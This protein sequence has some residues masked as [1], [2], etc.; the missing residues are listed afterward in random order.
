MDCDVF[1]I[2]SSETPSS[3]LR[4]ALDTPPRERFSE[5]RNVALFLYYLDFLFILCH[6]KSLV[7]LTKYR[8]GKVLDDEEGTYVVLVWSPALAYRSRLLWRGQDAFPG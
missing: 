5:S 1:F 2:G 8:R 6:H 7:S 3:Y 4:V